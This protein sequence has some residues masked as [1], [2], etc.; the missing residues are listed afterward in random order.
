MRS[1]MV[2]LAEPLVDDGLGLRCRGEPFGVQYF[3]VQGA[4]EA[5]V[6]AILP[7]RARIDLNGLYPDPK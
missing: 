7:W 2:V 1:D 4:I 6:I 5:F 3:P